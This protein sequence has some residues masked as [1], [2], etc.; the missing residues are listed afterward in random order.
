MLTRLQELLR[1]QVQTDRRGGTR[2]AGF[3]EGSG[4]NRREDRTSVE[5]DVEV[6]ACLVEVPPAV[7]C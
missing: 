5:E 1:A 7:L 2:A 4:F 3:G 6:A